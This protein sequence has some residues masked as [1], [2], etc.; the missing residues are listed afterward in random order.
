M[1]GGHGQL[2]VI[3]VDREN[4]R[5]GGGVLGK[6]SAVDSA[7]A[8]SKTKEIPT[9]TTYQKQTK[10]DETMMNIQIMAKKLISSKKSTGSGYL[11]FWLSYN[12]LGD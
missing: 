5:S 6:A 8:S 1:L 11:G 12:N 3:E 9:E 10:T 2:A 7:G 4:V